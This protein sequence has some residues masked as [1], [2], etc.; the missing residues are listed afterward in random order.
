MELSPTQFWEM[1]FS[2]ID[3]LC[4]RKI[5]N[6]D[7]DSKNQIILAWYIEAFARQKKLPKLET[8]LKTPKVKKVK[9]ENNST[10]DDLIELARKKGMKLPK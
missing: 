8:L 1:T 10:D 2:E 5:K 7:D 3:V 6:N 9:K 4:D